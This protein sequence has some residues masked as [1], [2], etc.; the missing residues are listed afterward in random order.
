MQDQSSRLTNSISMYTSI[1]YSISISKCF[2]YWYYECYKLMI[3][4]IKKVLKFVIFKY[5]YSGNINSSQMV[6]TFHSPFSRFGKP[7]PVINTCFQI[8]AILKI[9]K[10]N[11]VCL[12]VRLISIFQGWFWYCGL[13]ALAFI[14]VHYFR[15]VSPLREMKVTVLIQ[16]SWHQIPANIKVD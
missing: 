9:S 16:S 5:C 8:E 2:Q 15:F 7:K 6:T 1:I 10:G 14:S 12:L 4:D 11:I 13:Y 3:L